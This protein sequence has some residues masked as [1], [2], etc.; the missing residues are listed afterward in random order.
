MSR[1]AANKIEKWLIQTS[2]FKRTA[3]KQFTP[4]RSTAGASVVI[5]VHVETE[6]PRPIAKSAVELERF[7]AKAAASKHGK[8]LNP[9]IQQILNS[10]K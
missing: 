6:L 5:K 4:P 10:K 3:E 1:T 2:Q 8:A 7:E 9:R